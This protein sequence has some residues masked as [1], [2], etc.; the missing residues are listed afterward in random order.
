MS[1]K[2]FLVVAD[3]ERE[4][5]VRIRFADLSDR[6]RKVRFGGREIFDPRDGPALSFDILPAALGRKD[7]RYLAYAAIKNYGL[8]KLGGITDKMSSSEDLSEEEIT[9]YIKNDDK[10]ALTDDLLYGGADYR[11]YLLGISFADMYAAIK[12]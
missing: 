10:I 7:G 11:K 5:N 12:G 4:Q 9:D 8:V 1:V 2:I 6:I 3:T